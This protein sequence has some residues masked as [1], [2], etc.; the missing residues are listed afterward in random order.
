MVETPPTNII[1]GFL[2]GLRSCTETR[3][4]DC[5]RGA[6]N[7]SGVERE[8][9]SDAPF[10]DFTFP[11]IGFGYIYTVCRWSLKNW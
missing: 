1:P 8:A 2:P 6:V 10:L 4:L 3:V 5:D 9:V 7:L 11:C